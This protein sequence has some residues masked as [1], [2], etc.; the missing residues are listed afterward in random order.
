MNKKNFLTVEEN[1]L[2][3]SVFMKK[4]FPIIRWFILTYPHSINFYGNARRDVVKFSA[5]EMFNNL[6]IIVSLILAHF[7]NIKG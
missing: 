6:L 2:F 3:L 4:K 1:L 7:V 5:K